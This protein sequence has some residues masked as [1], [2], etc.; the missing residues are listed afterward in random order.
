MNGTGPRDDAAAARPAEALGGVWDLLDALPRGAAPAT[1]TATT[2]DM[3]AVEVDPAATRAAG[4]GPTRWIAPAAI[5]AAMFVAGIAGGRLTA[6]DV[7]TGL[8][9]ALPLVHHLD[10]LREAGSPRFLEEVAQRKFALPPRPLLRQSPETLE[11]EAREF[12]A[13]IETLRSR[14]ASGGTPEDRLALRRK[15]LEDVPLEEQVELEKSLR[16]F[17]R[18]SASERRA[19]AEVARALVDP[20]RRDLRNAALLW[21]TW[22]GT[23]KPED[24]PEVVARGTDKR[25]GWLEWYLSRPQPPPRPEPR[26]AETRPPPADRRGPSLRPEG[27]PPRPPGIGGRPEIPAPPR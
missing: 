12:H 15:S 5:V 24:R 27:G 11:R 19:L 7:D 9:A 25:L 13:E 3:L 16:E 23:I 18:L 8:L 4:A 2:L 14:L 10:L 21:H 22:L 6:P 20:G 26:P 17:Q 1:M